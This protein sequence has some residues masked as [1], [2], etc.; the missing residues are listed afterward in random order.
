MRNDK[1]S[2]YKEKQKELYFSY[3]NTG[4]GTLSSQ[5]GW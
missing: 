3:V 5:K 4:Q 2:K 1:S